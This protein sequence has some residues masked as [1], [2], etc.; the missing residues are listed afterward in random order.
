MVTKGIIKGKILNSNKYYVEIPY[1][2]QAT[3]KSNGTTESLLE[4]TLSHTPGIVNSY[5]EGDVVYVSFEEHNKSNPV[6]IGKLYLDKNDSC[7]YATFDALKVK[8]NVELPENTT[9]S[10]TNLK[11][12]ILNT[13][14]FIYPVGSIYM[15]VNAISPEYLFGGEWERIEGQF[16]LGAT[17]NTVSTET[18]IQ[19][20][21]NVGPGGQGGE[22]SHQLIPNEMPKHRHKFE[23]DAPGEGLFETWYIGLS[24]GG[25][26]PGQS[27][28]TTPAPNGRS[29][30]IQVAETGGGDTHNNM[31]PFLAVY[32]WKRVK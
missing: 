18:N 6:I 23:C 27:S 11:S 5:N 28:V 31:P 1:L 15:S 24:Q 14:D 9:I 21:A 25:G 26:N 10:G 12:L 2:Q 3:V 7:G 17:G 4:A 22:A 16:L 19:K 32:M 13:L 29:N 30:T 8:G 20:T